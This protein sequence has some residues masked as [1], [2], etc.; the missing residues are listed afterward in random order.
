[1]RLLTFTTRTQPGVSRLGAMLDDHVV[2]LAAAQQFSSGSQ[3]F[4]KTMREL[5][6]LGPAGLKRS[7]ELLEALR[8]CRGDVPAGTLLSEAEIRIAKA[9]AEQSPSDQSDFV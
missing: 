1:M 8:A 6:A 7:A 4:P 3:F 2:D 9:I 5:L